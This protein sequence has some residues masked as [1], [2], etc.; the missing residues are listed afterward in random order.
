MDSYRIALVVAGVVGGGTALVHGLLLQRMVVKPTEAL[1]ATE[2]RVS[3][4][5]RRLA[6][7]LLHFTTFNWFLSGFGLIV[8]AV[9]LEQHERLAIGLFAGSSFLFGAF[10]ALWAVRRLHPSWMLMAAAVVLIIFGL[11]PTLTGSG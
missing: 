9:W 6:V 10:S 7:S 1:L 11:T 5:M 8:A 2:G 4:P 3:T